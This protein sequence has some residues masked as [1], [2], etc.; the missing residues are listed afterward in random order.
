MG[1]NAILSTSTARST[2]TSATVPRVVA[3]FVSAPAKQLPVEANRR[4]S[5]G[6]QNEKSRPFLPLL[7]ATSIFTGCT[8]LQHQL[9]A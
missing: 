5:P 4:T 7:P 1:P 9:P 2:S 6:L 3:R 8:S